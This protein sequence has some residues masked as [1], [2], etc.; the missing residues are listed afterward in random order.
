MY[1]EKKMVNARKAARYM[2]RY[3]RHPAI[4]ESHTTGFD[5]KANTVT[6]WYT[7]NGKRIG[8]AMPALILLS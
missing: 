6:F 3:I 1:A 5:E 8:T 4:A 2:G 7:R